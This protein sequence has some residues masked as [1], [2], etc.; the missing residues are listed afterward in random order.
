M[1]QF[2]ALTFLCCTS[3]AIAQSKQ[4]DQTPPPPN[5]NEIIKEN[6]SSSTSE[7]R[8]EQAA[9]AQ[10]GHANISS[11]GAVPPDADVRIIRKADAVMEEYR[12]NGQLYMVKVIPKVGKAYYLYDQEG[13][14]KMIRQEESPSHLEPPRWTLFSW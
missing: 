14:G 1:R 5:L 6:A 3:I 8:K 4:E 13:R 7:A 10:E 2:L 9:Q 12:F 11:E